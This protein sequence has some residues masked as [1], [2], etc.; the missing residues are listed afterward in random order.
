MGG[1]GC[2]SG[3]GSMEIVGRCLSLGKFLPIRS[4]HTSGDFLLLSLGTSPGTEQLERK[5]R[6]DKDKDKDKDSETRLKGKGPTT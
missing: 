6:Q 4:T 5:H 2:V 3:S 1:C